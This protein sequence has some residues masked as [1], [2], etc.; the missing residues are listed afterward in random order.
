[1]MAVL[2]IKGKKL[3]NNEPFIVKPLKYDL[4]MDLIYTDR[5]L[6]RINKRD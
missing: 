4:L 1:M 5:H 3:K 6:R 2:K